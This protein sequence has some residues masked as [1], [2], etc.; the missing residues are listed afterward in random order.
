VSSIPHVH[1]GKLR[2]LAITSSKRF[3][4]LP[5]VPTVAESGVPG[6][7]SI[8]WAGVAVPAATPREIVMRLHSEFTKAVAA[9]DIRERFIRDGIE[10]VGS[11][12][13]QFAEHI[14]RER[15][16]WAKVVRDSG[17]RAD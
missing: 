16:K 8:S 9:P 15:I 1:A 6:Y 10:P 14:R 5:D 11:T 12:P 7:E 3:V 4:S 13:E 17:A 2:M